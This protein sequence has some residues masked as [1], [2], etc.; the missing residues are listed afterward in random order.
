[1]RTFLRALFVSC[2]APAALSASQWYAAPGAGSGCNPNVGWVSGTGLTSCPWTKDVAASGGPGGTTVQPGDTVWFKA[3][4]YNGVTNWNLKGTAANPIIVRNV[5]DGTGLN[6]RVT[7]DGG[8]SN[9]NGIW[10]VAGYYTWYWGMEIMSSNTDRYASTTDSWPTGAE[11]PRGECLYTVQD[12]AQTGSGL[13]FINMVAHDCRQGFSIWREATNSELNGVISYYNG[14]DAPDRTHGHGIYTQIY[15]GTRLIKDSVTWNNFSHGFHAYGGDQ[16]NV[17]FDGIVGFGIQGWNVRN[18]LFGG[19]PINN[20]LLT[21]SSFY[22]PHDAQSPQSDIQVGYGGNCTNVSITNNYIMGNM[23]FYAGCQYP[24]VVM[25]GNGIQYGGLT[26]LTTAQYPSNN[27]YLNPT[28]PGT[29]WVNLQKSDYESGRGLLAIHNWQLLD[30]VNVDISSIIPNG[31][32]YEVRDIQYLYGS[33]ILTGTYSGGTVP[34]PMTNTATE[35]GIGFTPPPHTSKQWGAFLVLVTSGGAPT[36]TPSNT[37]TF[38]PSNTPTSTFTPTVTPSRTPTPTS[39]FTPTSGGPTNTPTLTPTLTP[40]PVPGQC[41]YGQFESGTVTAPMAISSNVLAQGSLY[42]S[43]SVSDSTTYPTPP[44]GTGGKVDITLDG[45]VS[46]ATG[47]L[48]I[49]T[50]SSDGNHDSVYVGVN[51]SSPASVATHVFDTC[52]QAWPC[53]WVWRPQQDRA[54]CSPPQ[55]GAPL[56]CQPQITLIAG[57]NAISF[58]GR[59]SLTGLDAWAF[60]P[61][62]AVQPSDQPADTPTATPTVTSTSTPSSTPTVT[63]TWTPTQTATRTPTITNTPVNT[64]TSTPV[65]TPTNTFTPSVTRTPTPTRTPLPSDSYVFY[66]HVCNLGNGNREYTFYERKSLGNHNHLPVCGWSY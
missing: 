55:G 25:T 43:S 10:R 15:T 8:D 45:G 48:W 16:N 14:W 33:P 42:V 4:T 50:N 35:A 47:Y 5:Q 36:P 41:V 6:A 56:A 53:T 2:L 39:T 52:E 63:R 61:S 23:L 58:L 3:G 57:S 27:W 19:P 22:R 59:E 37:P 31:S 21:N 46:G 30:T 44:A 9:G 13:K 49:R 20:G 18:F 28:V 62:Q 34:I 11:L 64:A 38:T 54:L 12:A 24:S 60:C 1:M 17:T 32:N 51:T 29:N 40:T 65:F 26:G 66:R 7:F